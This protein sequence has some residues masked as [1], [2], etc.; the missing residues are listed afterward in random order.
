M[1]MIGISTF[2]RVCITAVLWVYQLPQRMQL[3]NTNVTHPRKIILFIIFCASL[4]VPPTLQSGRHRQTTIHYDFIYKT[5]STTLHVMNK[6]LE[7][8]L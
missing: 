5:I 4:A 7:I 1:N 2:F 8:R 3:Y 6:M